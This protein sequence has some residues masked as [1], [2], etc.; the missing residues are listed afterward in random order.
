MAIYR[1]RCEDCGNEEEV[2]MTFS[3]FD[4]FKARDTRLVA[5]RC[6]RC[7]VTALVVVPSAFT[8]TI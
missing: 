6:L 8:F 7:R 4:R 5:T 1:V 2:R 3:E